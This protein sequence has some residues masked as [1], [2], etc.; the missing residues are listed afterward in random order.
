MG[1]SSFKIG[2][3]KDPKKVIYGKFNNISPVG[4]PR[5]R[6]EDIIQMDTSKILEVQEWRR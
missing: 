2:R 3:Q 4:K 1:G 6:W 5:K